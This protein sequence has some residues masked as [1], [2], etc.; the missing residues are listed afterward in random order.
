M[1]PWYLKLSGPNIEIGHGFTAI[2]EP[3][4][5]VEIG[6]WGRTFNAGR[7]TIGDGCLMSPGARI[8]ASDEITLGNG[9]M[10]ANGAYITD[11]DWHGL[12]DRIDRD[13]EVRPVILEDNV[14]I[15]DHA[16]VLKG[17]TIGENS[18]VGAGSVVTSDIPPNVVVA[19]N[20]AKIVKHLDP[21]Q[22]FRTR[23]EMYANPE[24]LLEFFDSLDRK[25]LGP[26]RFLPWLWGVLHP[27]S[28]RKTPTASGE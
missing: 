5:R 3:H 27:R 21:E 2:N 4:R 26:N 12:Y 22:S 10:L 17:V 18:V 15:G 6:V 1:K 25:F 11:S 9:V 24:E 19:G 7:I 20:P 14:W 13:E 16:M 28:R 8:S 23:G